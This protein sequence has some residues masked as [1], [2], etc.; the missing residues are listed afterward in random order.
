[1]PSDI[2]TFGTLPNVL[3]ASN[4]QADSPQMEV[5]ADGTILI[6][7]RF[8][9]DKANAGGAL[10]APRSGDPLGEYTGVK[11]VTATSRPFKPDMAIIEVVLQGYLTLPLTIYEFQNS[12]MDRPIQMHPK[13]NTSPGMGESKYRVTQLTGPSAGAWLKFYDGPNTATKDHKFAGIEN[14]V[15]GSAQWRK[16][17]FSATPDFDQTDV[18]KLNAPE[19]GS[20]GA[21]VPDVSNTGNHWLK[22]EKTCRNMLR[23]ASILWEITEVWQ[24]NSLGWMPEIY[25]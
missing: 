24:Y 22:L 2:K 21:T 8:V 18:G 11:V 25:S 23:G 17:S 15:T 10:P 5:Q 14:Y 7:R 6:T 20:Y 4:Q 19:V 13:F 3:Q 9:V 1:M 16:T 12:R